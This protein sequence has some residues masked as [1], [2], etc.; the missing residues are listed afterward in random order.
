MSQSAEPV[1][2]APHRSQGKEAPDTKG[3]WIDTETLKRLG[4]LAKIGASK[5]A[6][7]YPTEPLESESKP[8][9]DTTDSVVYKVRHKDS[10]LDKQWQERFFDESDYEK[11]KLIHQDSILEMCK[12]VLLSQ[13]AQPGKDLKIAS[14]TE[15]SMTIHSPYLIDIMPQ[16]V[17]YYPVSKSSGSKLRAGHQSL[18]IVKP[19]RMLGGARPNLKILKEKYERELS[20]RDP[21]SEVEDE[22]V[23]RKRITVKH[24]ERLEHELEKVL[25]EP[26]R[27][28]FDGYRQTPPVASF[29]MLWLLFRPGTKVY[30]VINDETVCCRVLT[31]V[32]ETLETRGRTTLELRM[33][34][35]DFN[36]TH[37]DRRKHNLRIDSFEGKRE[38]LSL[39]AYPVAYSKDET[40]RGKLVNRGKKYMAFLQCNAPQCQ[41]KGFAFAK[42]DDDKGMRER[43]YYNGRVVVDP[44]FDYMEHGPPYKPFAWLDKTDIWRSKT[45]DG[46][47]NKFVNIDPKDPG[48]ELEDSHHMLISGYI[49][50]FTLGTRKW[51]WLHIDNLAQCIPAI[52][53]IN[54]LAIDPED[55][56]MIK[57]SVPHLEVRQRGEPPQ[58]STVRMD[59][60][61]GKGE[62]HIMLLHGPPGT[63]KTFTAE[64]LAEYS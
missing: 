23:K 47:M 22:E 8:N 11:Q 50:G 1:T 58:E 59:P 9:Q 41:Y 44:V 24:V 46:S 36:G 19:Y 57:A 16:V 64:C 42:Q 15:E 7:E 6:S 32:W 26:M 14:I 3:Q 29:D 20:A 18:E 4:Y 27:L 52:D 33:W 53:L 37:V 63:G 35:L 28:E 48:L 17:S 2:D 38:I 60:I 61:A 13:K 62:G 10:V 34:F 51:V 39:E 56:S 5:V 55:L 12:D 25:D 49:R 31:P 21:N 54:N 45:N 43:H 40:L 30:T